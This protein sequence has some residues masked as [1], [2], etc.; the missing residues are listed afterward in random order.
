MCLVLHIR[1][2]KTD[3]EKIRDKKKHRINSA[4]SEPTVLGSDDSIKW[5]DKKP[6]KFFRQKHVDLLKLQ[7]NFEFVNCFHSLKSSKWAFILFFK[8]TLP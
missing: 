5:G 7:G 1:I 8:F 3:T 2:D 6:G 4:V